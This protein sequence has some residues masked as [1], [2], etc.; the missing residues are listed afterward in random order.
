MSEEIEKQNFFLLQNKF[1]L[2]NPQ[3]RKFNVMK[4]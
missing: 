3:V 2:K 4:A 1:V